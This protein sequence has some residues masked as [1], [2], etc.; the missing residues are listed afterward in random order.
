MG[1]ICKLFFLNYYLFK[2][3]FVPCCVGVY[4]RFPLK[5]QTGWRLIRPAVLILRLYDHSGCL[6]LTLQLIFS[7]DAIARCLLPRKAIDRCPVFSER[8]RF[9]FSS[10]R[11]YP[12]IFC[13]WR[14]YYMHIDCQATLLLKGEQKNKKNRKITKIWS[15]N[16]SRS[17]LVHFLTSGLF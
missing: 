2:D 5:P 14:S 15:A 6:T 10:P 16:H 11:S 9:F 8:M 13:D 7:A 17:Q 3:P 4:V 1:H 12:I